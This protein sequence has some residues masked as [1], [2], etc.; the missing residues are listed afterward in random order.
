[1]LSLLI[2]DYKVIRQGAFAPKCFPEANC[3]LGRVFFP[4]FFPSCIHT[5]NYSD[6]FSLS[7][8]ISAN[9]G[10][11]HSLPCTFNFN[12]PRYT[13]RLLCPLWRPT[14]RS[15]SVFA[16]FKWKTVCCDGDRT[17]K[18]GFQPENVF[19]QITETSLRR[20]IHTEFNMYCSS[21][22]LL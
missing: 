7:I 22:H 21:T 14:W 11:P 16:A 18:A 4:L 2:K 5:A 12:Y 6:L 1:M 8:V 20:R 3:S 15:R 10:T 13:P 19:S 9:D 17:L